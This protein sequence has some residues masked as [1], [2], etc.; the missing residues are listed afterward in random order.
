MLTDEGDRLAGVVLTVESDDISQEV[1][2]DA[3]GA[4]EIVD[5][6]PDTYDLTITA[7][8]GRTIIGPATATFVVTAAG[9]ALVGPTFT[10]SAA[11]VT[12]T[13]PPTQPPT[14]PTT[15]PDTGAGQLPATGLGSE[16]FV[17]AAAGAAVLVVG[18]VLFLISRRRSNRD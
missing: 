6:P 9:E 5:L 12:P 17:W 15:P 4:Y 1:T 11:V 3:D 18:A 10:V 16:T 13:G 8:E 2:T 14:Q 7:P